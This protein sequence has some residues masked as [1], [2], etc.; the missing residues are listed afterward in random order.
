MIEKPLAYKMKKAQRKFGEELRGKIA[1]AKE[2]LAA[3]TEQD[4]GEKDT[5]LLKEDEE[6]G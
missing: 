3:V 5:A 1:A 6:N 4:A 2:A